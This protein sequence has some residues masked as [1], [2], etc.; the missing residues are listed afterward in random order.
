M[1]AQREYYRDLRE[2]LTRLEERGMLVRVTRPID[3]DRELHP[4]VRLQFRG[5]DAEDRKGWLFENVTDPSGRHY[6]MP[7]ALGCLASS[8]QIYA[9]GMACSVDEIGERWDA[10]LRAPL[11]PVNVERGACQEVVHVGPS[12]LEHG[13]LA[14]F[15]I[16]ISTPGFDNAPY[17]TAAHV[18]SRH[19]VTGVRNLG[20]YRCMLKAP[21]RLGCQISIH[22]QDLGRHWKAARKLGKPLE[23]AVVVGTTPNLSY[24]AAARVPS[25]I[26]EYAV[27]GAIAGSPVELVRCLTVDLEVPAHAEI[28]IEGVISTETLEMEGP[29][30]E[31]TGYMAS[32]APTL[33]LQV[34][35]I[36]HRRDAIYT[37]LT[38]QYPPSESSVLRSTGLEAVIRKVLTVDKKLAGITKV[39]LPD[40]VGA[41]GLLVIQVDQTQGARPR[42]IIQA[43]AS[44]GRYLG[45]TVVIVDDD[46]DPRNLEQIWHAI[47]YRAQAPR[48]MFMVPMMPNGLDPSVVPADQRGERKTFNSASAG[49]LL[50]DASRKWPYAPLSLPPRPIMEH[51]LA[52]WRELQLPALRLKEPWFGHPLEHW[53][54]ENAEEADLALDGRYWETGAKFAQQR[55]PADEIED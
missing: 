2:Y 25:D 3:K 54:A 34:T 6:E 9:L 28:V 4:L 43:L 27:A 26:E 44:G 7:V 32:R 17:M 55:R 40:E 24:S 53:N 47:A 30:G 37:A 22:Y 41:F 12:L 18:V 29:F 19:P 8:R 42:D 45:K 51:A 23:V 46:I 5:L 10:A 31:F 52:I 14:E 15:P 35:A 21:D 33:H 11:A 39:A 13:G 50:I 49:A 36:T 16:P 20:N 48:D 38:S 1:G